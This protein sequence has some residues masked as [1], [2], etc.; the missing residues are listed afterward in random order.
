M[1]KTHFVH[2]IPELISALPREIRK[3]IFK[4]VNDY[5]QYPESSDDTTWRL[6]TLLIKLEFK[7]FKRN[8]SHA[9]FDPFLKRDQMNEQVYK[10]STV[11]H[12]V[13]DEDTNW[14]YYVLGEASSLSYYIH[15]LWINL[16]STVI[17]F[18]PY[19]IHRS[20]EYAKGR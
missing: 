3:V 10:V 17:V 18:E 4:K 11:F 19:F 5:D 14:E 16:Y 8:E 7:L 2:K 12:H 20:R 6:W 15:W 13:I 9:I 1:G